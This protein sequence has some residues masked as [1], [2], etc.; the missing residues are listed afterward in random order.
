M[1]SA[2]VRRLVT[3]R[4]EDNCEYCRLR[5]VEEPWIR[6][7]VEHIVPRQHGGND[8]LTNLALA[9]LHCNVHK[10]PNLAGIDPKTGEMVR[11]FHPR[12]DAWDE[13]FEVVGPFVIGRS[14]IGRSS[15]RVM[16]MNAENR[17]WLRLRI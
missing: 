7:Q 12:V 15:V 5:Q 16:N 6:F 3:D 2:A 14:D 1:I 11:L 13:H 17:V 9:C 8:A 4:A 10:G